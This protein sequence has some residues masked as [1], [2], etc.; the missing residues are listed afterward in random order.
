MRKE[1]C[2]Q[3]TILKLALRKCDQIIA[4]SQS[5]KKSLV[6]YLG[7]PESKIQTIYNGV[8]T[9]RFSANNKANM[10]EPI[11]MIYVGRLIWEKGVQV[12]IKALSK[13]PKDIKW[14][15]QIVGD[16][17]YRQ[18]LEELVNRLNLTS[19]ISFLGTRSDVPQLFNNADIFIHMPIWEE[20][21]GIAIV[22]AMAAGLVCICANSGAISEIIR[23]GVNGYLVEK[24]NENVLAQR[25]AC[26]V[27]DGLENK[28]QILSEQAVSDARSFSVEKFVNQLDDIM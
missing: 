28:L 22:E 7:T 18:N 24:E 27:R 1:D 8:D 14:R 25:I 21:F 5:V 20:G 16:G 15:F 26:A 2:F 11:N 9:S 10:I 3:K 13:L 6:E 19:R 23:D 17:N 12:T 4:I